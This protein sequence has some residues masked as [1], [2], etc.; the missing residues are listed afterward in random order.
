MTRVGNDEKPAVDIFQIK[1]STVQEHIK[2]N[3]DLP[4]QQEKFKTRPE[5][6][7]AVGQTH[8]VPEFPETSAVDL[9]EAP[10]TV[11]SSRSLGYSTLCFQT[12]GNTL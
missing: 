3:V 12:H 6:A 2:V 5:R 8:K 7:G 1:I 10:R 4:A 9:D 11:V